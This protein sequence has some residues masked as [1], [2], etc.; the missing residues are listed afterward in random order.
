M[1]PPGDVSTRLTLCSATRAG[2]ALGLGLLLSSP[3]HAPAA[4]VARESAELITKLSDKGAGRICVEHRSP[5]HSRRPARTVC[6]LCR[7]GPHRRRP[8]PRGRGGARPAQ[9]RALPPLR[10]EHSPPYAAGPSLPAQ[11]TACLHSVPCRI[12][13]RSQADRPR[14]GRRALRSRLPQHCV[15]AR[16]GGTM[17][18]R[19]PPLTLCR[20]PT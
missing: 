16:Q 14:C 9:D 13:E 6:V 2:A 7:A 11:L 19:Y 15:R 8:A 20:L 5:A 1:H 12:E 3:R 18:S 17:V 10:C 4:S